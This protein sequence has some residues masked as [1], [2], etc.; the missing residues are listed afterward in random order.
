MAS[1]FRQIRADTWEW[2]AR[3]TIC[4]VRVF[5]IQGTLVWSNRVETGAGPQFGAGT[6]QTL[7]Q[8]KVNGPPDEYNPPEELVDALNNAVTALENPPKK[9]GLLGRLFGKK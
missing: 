4:E 3:N 9:R 8:F 7:E 1:G 2:D 5:P 6:R